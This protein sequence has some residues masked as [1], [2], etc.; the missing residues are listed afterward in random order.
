MRLHD[1]LYFE[2]TAEGSR[3]ELD[4]FS[5]FLTSGVLDDY[6]EVSEDYIIP[7]DD[8]DSA[9]ESEKTTLVFSNDEYAI[10]IDSFDPESFLEIL[11]KGGKNL[12][13][14]GQLFD[15]DDT[16][17]RF[18]S[19]EGDSSFVDADKIDLFNDELD[20]KALEEEEDEEKD[21]ADY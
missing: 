16:E 14:T 13:L 18:I 7:D 3:A 1:E 17:Y 6:F 12:Y 5:A 15:C 20:A 11:C 21:E 9:M 8:Y 4:R 19:N 10:E 2:I